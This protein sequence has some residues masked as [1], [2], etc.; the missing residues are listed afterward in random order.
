[1][2]AA[3][4]AQASANAAL[5]SVHEERAAR[6]REAEAERLEAEEAAKAALRREEEARRKAVAREKKDK[7]K[8]KKEGSS[9]GNAQPENAEDGV[10]E[11]DAALAAI[12]P[13]SSD[14]GGT[15]ADAGSGP[16]ALP[17]GRDREAERN[18]EKLKAKVQEKIAGG[19][20]HKKVA[21]KP[22]K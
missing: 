15:P 3:A 16:S 22:K 13:S 11:I 12:G 9:G 8:Q 1:M 20:S 4:S 17:W 19:E 21:P 6:Q 10:D 5:L 7:R 2:A 18:R 14:G